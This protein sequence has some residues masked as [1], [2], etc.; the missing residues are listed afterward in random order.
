MNLTATKSPCHRYQA[1]FPAA[2]QGARRTVAIPLPYSRV[3]GSGLVRAGIP[4]NLEMFLRGVSFGVKSPV[5]PV[6]NLLIRA[7]LEGY[8]LALITESEVKI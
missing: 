3:Q 7:T 5:H 6:Y 8:H 1:L 4:E 2:A